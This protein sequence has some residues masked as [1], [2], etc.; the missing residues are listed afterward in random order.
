MTMLDTLAKQIAPDPAIDAWLVRSWISPPKLLD[1]DVLM[2]LVRAEEG[3]LIREPRLLSWLRAE[4][5]AWA[6]QRYRRVRKLATMRASGPI[7]KDG[8]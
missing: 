5:T 8:G 3:R 2:N 4:W 1:Q 7:T 6:R